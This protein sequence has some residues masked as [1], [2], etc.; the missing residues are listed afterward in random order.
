MINIKRIAK[1]NG[2]KFG[3]YTNEVYQINLSSNYGNLPSVIKSLKEIGIQITLISKR[4][5]Y[6]Y[7]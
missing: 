7:I 5:V 6:F 1:L 2:G 3:K 4:C